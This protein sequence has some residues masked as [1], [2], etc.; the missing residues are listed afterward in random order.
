MKT[1]R[2]DAPAL[3][4]ELSISGM[5][6]A[7][8][9][10]KVQAGLA[11]IDGVDEAA[12][13]FAGARATI[14][15]SGPIDHGAVRR[16]V[17][18]A[19]YEVVEAGAAE[20]AEQARQGDLQR[21]LAVAAPLGTAIMVVSMVPLLQFA[22]W[23]WAV[24]A[25]SVPVV[26]WCAWPFHRKALT[27]LARRS[28]TMDTLVSIGTLAA[29]GFSA[30]VLIAGIEGEHV[31]FETA[32]V[33]VALI[34]LGRW[35][36]ARARQRTGDAIRA[37]AEMGAGQA[38]L[39]DGREVPVAELAVGDRFL[40]R[41]GDRIATD[42]RV[43]EG[44]AAVDMSMI[45][46]E[47]VP[48]DIEAGDEVIGG[49]IARSGSLVVE[50]AKVGAETALAQILKLVQQAQDSKAGI[51]RLADRV[52]AVFVPA[53]MLAAAATLAAW[54]WLAESTG[55][56]F[57]A[58]VA[59]LIIACPCALGLATPL[60]IMVGTGRGAQLGVIIKGGEVLEDTRALDVA[61]LDKTG[62]VTE[63]E[64]A[65]IARL[66]DTAAAAE[67]ATLAAS[68]EQ[69]SEH[70]IAAAIARNV[71]ERRQV[72][73]FESHAG[74]GVSGVVDGTELAVGK[75]SLFRA[76]DDEVAQEAD[77]AAAA[78]RIAVYAG[79]HGRA[80]ALFVLADSVKAG[81]AQAVAALDRLGISTVLLSGDS[82]A[83][84]EAVAAEVGIDEVIAEVMPAEKAA[85]IRR[86]QSSGKRVAMVGDG[87]N[88]APALAAA[89][90]GIAVDTGTDVAVEASDIT[91]MGGDLRAVADAIALARRTLSVIKGNLFWA[92]AYNAAA[93]PLAAVGVLS[94]MIAAAAMGASSLFVVSNSLRL[95]RFRGSR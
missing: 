70:P 30:A 91:V 50:A 66:P 94:P 41:P 53:A 54:L 29:F 21:R 27:G 92:F 80:E 26:G 83:V 48:A 15:H 34:L 62:T 28:T 46:G 61:V 22:G 11:G 59:V 49:T 31:Y 18:A 93:V 9:A 87:I 86:L 45:T 82:R 58:A 8:C 47:P 42:G 95:R 78:G 68:L 88:D 73:R 14:R 79:R 24:G 44:A 38:V 60:A 67:V 51:E 75:D 85:V 2:P 5:T 84:A 19:G 64:M 43:L 33:I 32:A 55:D 6:C 12:V 63:G 77:E 1:A 81:S 90:L 7:A 57:S 16:A 3:R 37:L 65:V 20:Q 56:A 52:A 4:T 72:Q 71:P 35:L 39:V 17:E 25:A 74:V 13:N 36:E 69:R 23:E 76:V 10:A 40:V 89:D